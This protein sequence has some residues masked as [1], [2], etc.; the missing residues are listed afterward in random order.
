MAPDPIRRFLHTGGTLLLSGL[1]LWALLR[2]LLTWFFPFLE[3]EFKV[4]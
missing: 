4:Q 2:L 1:L 3:D